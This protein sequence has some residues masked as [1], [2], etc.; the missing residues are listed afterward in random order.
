LLQSFSKTCRASFG[1]HRC[2]VDKELYRQVYEIAEM[3]TKSVIIANIDKEDCYFNNGD[4]I[5][6]AEQFR[7]KIQSHFRDN[8]ELDTLIP[9]N[10]KDFKNITLITGCDK[11]FITC[12]N[13]FNNAVNFRGEPLIPNH[14]FLKV[15][16]R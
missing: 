15:S 8:I 9:D 14:N 1:D 4:A 3:N 13:K 2:K 10:I 11:N 16:L 12:C 6:G 5:F 7:A